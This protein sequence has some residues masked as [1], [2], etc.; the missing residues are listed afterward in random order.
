MVKSR[1]NSADVA[2]SVACMRRWINYRVSNV[3]DITPK[4]YQFK[5]SKSGGE[6]K[7]GH[8]T[9][10]LME[11]AVRAHT[12]TYAREKNS[13]PSNFCLKLRKHL[14]TKRLEKITQLGLD[15]II[16][17]AFGQG[18]A[19]YH[20]ILELYAQ[21]NLVLTDCN[22]EILTLLRSYRD[23]ERDFAI[24]ARHKYPIET[25]RERPE[26]SLRSMEQ[27][28]LSAEPAN[29]GPQADHTTLKTSVMDLL[30]ALGPMIC[31]HCI[32][33]CGLQSSR[34]IDDE[35]LSEA[36]VGM[37]FEAFSKF[38]AWLDRCLVE[39]VPGYVL[40]KELQGT[41]DSDCT[42]EIYQDCTP[43]L[44]QPQDMLVK[45]F[46]TFDD[47][48]DEFFAQSETQKDALQRQQQKAAAYSKVEKV[49]ADHERRVQALERE[50]DKS[51]LRARLIEENLEEVDAAIAAVNQ[52]IASGMA[53]EEVANLIKQETKAGNPV[54]AL[55][56]SLQLERNQVTLRLRDPTSFDE[57][58][59]D[60][61]EDN[62][63][64]GQGSGGEPNFHNVE[65]D[66]S[67]SAYKNVE[68]HFSSKK[69]H[70][71][72][73]QKTLDSNDIAL[74]QAE[75]KAQ[76]A[77]KKVKQVAKISQMRKVF[78]FEKFNWFITTENFLVVGGRDAQQNEMVVKKYL[79]GRNLY[80]HADLHGAS[81]CVLIN[82]SDD[83][84]PAASL[85]QAGAFCVCRSQAWDSKIVTSAWWVYSNQVSKTAPTGEYLTTG[86]FMVRGRKNFLPP[87]PLVM[88]YGL[89][90]MLDDLSLPNHIGERRSVPKGEL[91]DFMERASQSAARSV[92]FRTSD[93]QTGS[94][95]AD[96][97]P[98]FIGCPQSSGLSGNASD[99]ETVDCQEQEAHHYAHGEADEATDEVETMSYERDSD[100]LHE[101]VETD[102]RL[103]QEE[104]SADGEDQEESTQEAQDRDPL[105]S[106]DCTGLREPSLTEAG[107]P[108]SQLSGSKYAFDQ[109]DALDD[110]PRLEQ[111]KEAGERHK[112]L[113]KAQRR[114][115]KKG[116]AHSELDSLSLVTDLSD[117]E[118]AG[119][120]SEDGEEGVA[121][122]KPPSTQKQT[123]PVQD[124]PKHSQRGKKGKLKKM[125][126]KYADQ[127]EEERELRMALLGSRAKQNRGQVGAN[128]KEEEIPKAHAGKSRQGEQG[129]KKGAQQ[130]QTTIF[131]EVEEDTAEAGELIADDDTELDPVVKEQL[132]QIDS[133]TSA[134]TSEDII[135][136]CLPVC[137]PYNTMASYK[138]KVKITPGSMKKGRAS[139]Q[140]M[141]IFSR[142][143]NC[144]P[145]ERELIKSVA[146]ADA[147][148]P[149]LGSVKVNL[150]GLQKLQQD[151][152][153]S[154]KQKAVKKQS[155]T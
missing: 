65:V 107:G 27:R 50:V 32:I 25:F 59:S 67:L 147:I 122:I 104:M 120:G 7:E 72:K 19:C 90:F 109:A 71:H 30:P 143:Q 12:T 36:E 21:G 135:H 76:M 101:S 46:D 123:P 53:W 115:I 39:E 56:H 146:D 117:P 75:R 155:G 80:V 69:K 154:K 49:K 66:L 63:H 89:L 88:G 83:E 51:Q 9:F 38:Y 85:S 128:E 78:W 31:E 119:K 16:D 37:L 87:T 45:S 14:R 124:E 149:M 62:L 73:Q 126:K 110:V 140:A 138:Y 24:L 34:R 144:T 82:H 81:S 97:E 48:L 28:L 118:L 108:E 8:K 91:G 103:S 152:K 93:Q 148:A 129:R 33:E 1:M 141:E 99:E 11:S 18:E 74:K 23:N 5:L 127:D 150:P 100:E 60:D 79:K 3:Y 125:K 44:F 105:S 77:L 41:G 47:A 15:R 134:P 70:A 139:R 29:T 106:L 113:S 133:L 58:M 153:K 86:S 96:V 111:S 10:I 145:R 55:V 22:Y 26:L 35:P 43:L 13:M 114:A 137:A 132:L 112:Y 57:G 20:V 40:Y 92:T 121:P 64:H 130:P 4:L 42:K 54:A 17:F 136:F 68:R 131:L 98:D 84:V 52:V 6:D 102:P 151:I 116:M 142:A 95:N 61:D 94:V 2:A